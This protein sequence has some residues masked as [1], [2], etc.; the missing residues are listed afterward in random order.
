M[1]DV[2][3]SFALFTISLFATFAIERAIIPYLSRKAKQPI[4]TDGPAWHISKSGTPTMGGIGFIIPICAL[5]TFVGL[6]NIFVKNISLG[7]SL[8]ITVLYALLNSL[9][10]IFDD[11]VKLKRKNNGGLTPM[12]KLGLQFILAILFLMARRFYF[13]DSPHLSFSFGK[14][15]LGI[16]YYPIAAIILL[17]IVNCA[18]LTDGIDGLS[19]SVFIAISTMAFLLYGSNPVIKIIA[20]ISLPSMLAFL[21]FN[22]NPAKVFMGDTGSLFLGAL[23]ASM[24]FCIGNPF[25]SVILGG[26]YVIEGVSVILQVIAFKLTKKRLFRMAP[27]HHHFEKCGMKENAICVIATIA[28][29]IFSAVCCLAIKG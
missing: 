20:V 5:L 10:G 18:N 24:G 23:V 12:Q 1:L 6:Q 4:Y 19:S 17:G 2:A 14:I 28:T 27:I 13:D 22:A 3:T 9:I 26:V 25:S 8:I 21:F 16:L 29:L 11:L 15:D 7:V